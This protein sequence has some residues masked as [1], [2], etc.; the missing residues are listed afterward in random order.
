MYEYFDKY[1]D[2]DIFIIEPL[3]QINSQKEEKRIRKYISNNI[4]KFP[5]HDLWKFEQG[6][7]IFI[8]FGINI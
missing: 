4:N 3:Q 8:K 6:Y 7:I 2:D 1:Y 5:N